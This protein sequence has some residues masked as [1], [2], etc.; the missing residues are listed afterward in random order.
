MH[1]EAEIEEA[2]VLPAWYTG[3]GAMAI[4]ALLVLVHLV[5]KGGKGTGS[6]GAQASAGKA[7]GK[8]GAAPAANT[9]S[10]KKSPKQD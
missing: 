1:V 8:A 5:T 2:V 10:K 9:R 4:A 6:G 7:A 3:G